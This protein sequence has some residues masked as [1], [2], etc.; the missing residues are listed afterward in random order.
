M[1]YDYNPDME[2]D[3]FHKQS[4]KINITHIKNALQY[5]FR[6][7]QIARLGNNH[8]IYPAFD[9]KSFKKIINLEL[10]KIIR[11]I[12]KEYQINLNIDKSIHTVIYKEG[13]FP[14]QGTRPV[15]TIIY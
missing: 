10:N 1:S 3:E 11:K 14:T 2:A 7:E 8:I 9:S 13:V 4:L 15:F 5:R 6:N 12:K